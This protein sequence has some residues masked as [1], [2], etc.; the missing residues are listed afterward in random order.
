MLTYSS[1]PVTGTVTFVGGSGGNENLCAVKDL[2]LAVNGA[3]IRAIARFAQNNP[4]PDAG[5]LD[6]TRP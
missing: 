6:C 1:F 5:L 2:T 4:A 3:E